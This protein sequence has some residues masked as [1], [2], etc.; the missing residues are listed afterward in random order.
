MELEHGWHRANTPEVAAQRRRYL[1]EVLAV[2]PVEPFTREMGILAAR[3]DAD[4]RKAGFVIATADLLIGVTALYY[5]YAIGTRNGRHFRM[6]PG[7]VVL[8]V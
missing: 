8:S 5:G 7:L 1:D 2:L 3:I 4:I 6:I